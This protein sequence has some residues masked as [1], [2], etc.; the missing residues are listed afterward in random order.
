[1]HWRCNWDRARRSPQ[2]V[3]MVL[4]VCIMTGILNEVDHTSI[5]G[6]WLVERVNQMKNIW[7]TCF[8]NTSW[9]KI[10]DLSVYLDQ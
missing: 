3:E 8:K 10:P 2:M 9:D 7:V 4:D 6:M 5:I 1:M